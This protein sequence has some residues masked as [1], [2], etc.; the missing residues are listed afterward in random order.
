M[1]TNLVG[2]SGAKGADG[3]DG[4]TGPIGPMGLQGPAG[5][6]GSDATVA[7]QEVCTNV[8]T[9]YTSSRTGWWSGW[10]A[11]YTANSGTITHT[12]YRSIG[13]RTNTTGKV[14]D[15]DVALDFG[16]HLIYLRRARAYL[17]LDYRVLINGGSGYNTRQ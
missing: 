5:Q 17:W 14:V 15:M 7:D 12:P 6:D 3:A 2:C 9:P 16:E 1:L 8:R 13:T 11:V 4:A 10:T